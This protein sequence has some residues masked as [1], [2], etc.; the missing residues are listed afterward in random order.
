VN[1]VAAPGHINLCIP[2]E[3]HTDSLPHLKA[4][5]TGCSISMHCSAA[6]SDIADRP[7]DLP[8][9]VGVIA[10]ALGPALPADAPAPGNANVPA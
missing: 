10:D 8:F 4:G 3:V 9:P 2:G 6:A 7:R 1:V 5:A